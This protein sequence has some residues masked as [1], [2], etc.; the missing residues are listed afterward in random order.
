M[1]KF[2][3]LV[4]HV[5]ALFAYFCIST[6]VCFLKCK[7]PARCVN[8]ICLTFHHYKFWVLPTECIYEFS[9]LLSLNSDYLPKHYQPVDRYNGDRFILLQVQ[10]EIINV[11]YIRMSFGI[12]GLITLRL[13]I[14]TEM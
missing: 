9:V 1:L 7:Y 4:C 10:T 8:C 5:I 2:G 13:S 14:R 3:A 12:K 11:I 6:I